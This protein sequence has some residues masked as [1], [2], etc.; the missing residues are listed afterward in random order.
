MFPVKFYE[1]WPL[2]NQNRRPISSHVRS[3]VISHVTSMLGFMLP[4]GSLLIS[5]NSFI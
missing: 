5:Q 4:L 1:K 3:D 2:L